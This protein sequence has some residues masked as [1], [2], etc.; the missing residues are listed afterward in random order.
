M[1]QVALLVD[2]IAHIIAFLND[3]VNRSAF[4]QPAALLTARIVA[5]ELH[6]VLMLEISGLEAQETF[7]IGAHLCFVNG[8]ISVL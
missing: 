1:A 7:D 5:E 8:I 2:N 6:Y 3:R 4:A